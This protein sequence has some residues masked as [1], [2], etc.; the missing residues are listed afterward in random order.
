MVHWSTKTRYYHTITG[1]F[2]GG[3]SDMCN[4]EK[5]IKMHELQ[6]AG[7]TFN[8]VKNVSKIKRTKP[9]RL[10]LFYDDHPELVHQLDGFLRRA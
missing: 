10:D 9:K 2:V 7:K 1:S 5:W 6:E 3:N 4:R 8:I